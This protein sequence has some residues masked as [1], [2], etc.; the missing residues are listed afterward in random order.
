MGTFAVH[1][2]NVKI[3]PY[4]R[5][6]EKTRKSSVYLDNLGPQGCS[7]KKWVPPHQFFKGKALGTRMILRMCYSIAELR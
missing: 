3:L 2:I 6:V 7:L 1:V 4:A 5:I